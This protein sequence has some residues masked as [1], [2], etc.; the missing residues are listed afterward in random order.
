MLGVSDGHIGETIAH[1]RAG[2]T[3]RIETVVLWLGRRS[4][5]VQSVQEVYRPEQAAA[6]DYFKIPP[7][8]MRQLLGH[9][10]RRRLQVL[11]Q[12]HSHPRQAFHS[13]ADDAWAI[14]RHV[15]AL[16]LVIPWFGGR[17]TVATFLTDTAVFELDPHNRWREVAS[18]TALRIGGDAGA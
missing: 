8:S 17:T 18:R 16:S 11:A 14:V 3:R 7:T 5:D 6:R 4:E 12:C 13:E 2:G 1:L 10:R 15:G 9:L